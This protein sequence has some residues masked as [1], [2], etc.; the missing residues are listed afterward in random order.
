MLTHQSGSCRDINLSEILAIVPGKIIGEE[1]GILCVSAES[2]ELGAIAVEDNAVD[3]TLLDA[4]AVVGIGVCGV[5]VEDPEQAGAL[6]DED[7]V[8]LVLQ[9]D[10]RLWSVQP[11]V[12]LLRPVHGPVEVVEKL[13]T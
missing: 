2:A 12:F 10:V 9:R 8:S 1:A 7:L 11:A 13:V 3:A 6:E 4:D 5:E